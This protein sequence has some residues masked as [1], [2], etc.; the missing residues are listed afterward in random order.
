M[1]VLDFVQ[2]YGIRFCSNIGVIIKKRI[3][4]TFIDFNVNGN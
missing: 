3:E 1:F 4:K 2:N